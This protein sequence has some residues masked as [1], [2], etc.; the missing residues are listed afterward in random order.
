ME[1]CFL[2]SPAEKLL[3]NQETNISIFGK[4]VIR[5]LYIYF[6]LF[7]INP[8]L[9]SL[10][11]GAKRFF[12][13]FFALSVASALLACIYTGLTNGNAGLCD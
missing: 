9:L 7:L 5:V 12:F 2:G 13:P 1:V 4:E 3:R 11:G 10:P 8:L 6:P